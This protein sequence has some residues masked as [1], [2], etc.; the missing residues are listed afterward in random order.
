M[1]SAMFRRTVFLLLL[2]T[3]L[4]AP[5]ASAA[6]GQ[7]ADRP[8]E[9]EASPLELLGRVWDFLKSAWSESGCRLDPNGRCAPAPQ[10]QTDEGCRLD[11]NGGCGA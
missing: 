3:V 8:A 6:V 7:V 10:P 2:L 5:W 9:S 4:T 11:P 1:Q